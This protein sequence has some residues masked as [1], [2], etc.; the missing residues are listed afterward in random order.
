MEKVKVVEIFWEGDNYR[1]W[2]SIFRN[3]MGEDKAEENAREIIKNGN[4]LISKNWD[5]GYELEVFEIK[6]KES[7][8]KWLEVAREINCDSEVWEERNFFVV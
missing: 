8:I 2:Y 5:W 4:K 7:F 1:D 3:E 6:D